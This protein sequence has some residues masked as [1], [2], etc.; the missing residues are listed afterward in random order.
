MES[1][2]IDITKRSS[3]R[4][5]TLKNKRACVVGSR[6]ITQQ[7]KERIAIIGELLAQLGISGASGNA[8]GSDIEWDNYMFVQHFLPWDGHQSTPKHPKRYHGEN[9]NQY[10]ALNYCPDSVLQKAMKIMEEH[11][12]YGSS[13]KQGPRKM[14]TRNV[15]QALGVHLDERTYADLT[16]YTSEETAYGKVKGGTSTAVEISRSHKIPTFNL[17]IDSQYHKLR[18]M[19]EDM[20]DK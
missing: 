20:L 8:E 19:L 9:N 2:M 12:P 6:K 17:R 16:V 10:L 1:K 7:D 13:L 14:H 15:F 18:K 4:F 5:V 3:E 11:H